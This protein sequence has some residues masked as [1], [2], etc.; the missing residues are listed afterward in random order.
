VLE[1]GSLALPLVASKESRL[2]LGFAG[3]GLAPK[4]LGWNM[5]LMLVNDASN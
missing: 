3:K 2:I 5:S 4:L 1:K